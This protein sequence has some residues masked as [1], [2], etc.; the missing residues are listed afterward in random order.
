MIGQIKNTII[1][2]VGNKYN[3]DGVKFSS[4]ETYLDDI[5]D[6]IV[7]MLEKS[8]KTDELYQF[9]FY[10]M[11]TLNPIYTFVKNIFDDPQH[12]IK[13]SQNMSRY[14]YEKSTHPKIKSGELWVI[15]LSNCCI[16]DIQTDAICIL[17]SETKKTIL[18]LNQLDANYEVAKHEGL[19]LNKIDKGCIIYNTQQEDGYVCSVIDTGSKKGEKAKFWIDDFLH[20]RHIKN[21]YKKTIAVVDAIATYVNNE[22]PKS[23]EVNKSEQALIIN[24]SLNEIKSNDDVTFQKVK[25]VAFTN[26]AVREDF[27]RYLETYQV[28]NDILLAEDVIIEKKAIKGL[29]YNSITTIKLDKNFDI[30]VHG[31]K[32]LIQKGYDDDLKMSFYK[33]YFKQEK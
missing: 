22:L 17:K 1:H 3:A 28:N 26:T 14:L 4:E 7:K 16:D 25:K 24:N 29:N 18:Q 5:S 12:Y 30:K 20:V 33:L 31:G 2:Q 13:E 9:Y 15:Y 10:P 11:L 27:E 19:G 8:F 23:F 21:G 32:S 6:D